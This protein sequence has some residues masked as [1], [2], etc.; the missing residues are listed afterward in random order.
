MGSINTNERQGRLGSGQV[1]ILLGCALLCF[2][3]RG[4][5][6]IITIPIKLI[7]NFDLLIIHNFNAQ[8]QIKPKTHTDRL[9]YS[10]AQLFTNFPQITLFRI[11]EY[12]GDCGKGGLH[13]VHTNMRDCTVL[14]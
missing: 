7:F 14:Y 3:Y 5:I 11:Q 10:V 2:L 13:Q 12:S 8:K 9:I 4:T 1:F 6:I